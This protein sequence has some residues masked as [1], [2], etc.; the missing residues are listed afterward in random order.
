MVVRVVVAMGVVVRVVVAMVVEAMV[1]GMGVET[2]VAGMVTEGSTVASS[3]NLVGGGTRGGMEAT[4]RTGGEH[5]DTMATA[6]LGTPT[7]VGTLRL[8]PTLPLC[9][10][11]RTT[12][13]LSCSKHPLSRLR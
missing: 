11:R 9:H 4:R 5:P 12:T 3:S 2:M 8:T 7:M 1:A 13:V 10:R 6:I